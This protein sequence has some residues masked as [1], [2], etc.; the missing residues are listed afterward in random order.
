MKPLVNLDSLED[1]DDHSHKSF[2]AK[3]SD[4]GAKIGAEKLG[5]NLTIVPPGKKSWPFHNHHISEEMFLVI[6]GTGLL[7]FGDDEYSV[8]KNDVIA[9]P[10]GKRSVAHQF[11]NNSTKD[12]KYLALGTKATQDICEYPD[13]DKI[14][15][16]SN[17][18]GESLLWNMS[19]TEESYDYF[20]DEE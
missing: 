5:Y 12:L 19:K 15:A 9:C 17:K 11:I 2:Q 4:I 10:V 6:E 3:Y 7:R 8:K 18:D 1:F 13:S 14:L 20:E 16:R